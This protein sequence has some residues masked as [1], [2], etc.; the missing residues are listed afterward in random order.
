MS[1]DDPASGPAPYP[2][3]APE[4]STLQGD[5]LHLWGDAVVRRQ[6]LDAIVAAWEANSPDLA[7]AVARVDDAV[8]QGLAALGLPRGPIRGVRVESAGRGWIGLKHPDCTLLMDGLRVQRLVQSLQDCDRV[9]HT[10]VHE[11]LH[12]RRLYVDSLAVE[13]RRHRG[14]EEG[15]VEGLA[16]IVTGEKAGMKP[17][18]VS[19]DY[20]VQAYAALARA[21]AIGVE[22]LWRALWQFPAGAVRAEF[23]DALTRSFRQA[24]G[25]ALT[26]TQRAALWSLADQHFD[27]D[28]LARVPN[29]VLLTA[30]WKVAL[31]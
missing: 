23:G 26:P 25:R 22:A 5:A 16:R 7:A 29:D 10:W 9:F 24:H 13:Q 15:M 27:S 31:R 19:F 21:C 4:L 28:R 2:H 17:G 6:A 14:Y 11:S 8:V 30:S 3:L 12:G 20:Y 18:M 1:A